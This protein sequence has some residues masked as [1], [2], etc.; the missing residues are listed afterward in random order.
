MTFAAFTYL[1]EILCFSALLSTT[2]LIELLQNIML[3][4]VTCAQHLGR[5][6]CVTPTIP[7]EGFHF[8]YVTFIGFCTF[9]NKRLNTG[10]HVRTSGQTTVLILHLH[11]HSMMRIFSRVSALS[12]QMNKSDL[13]RTT[14][15]VTIT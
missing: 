5:E 7:F 4:H 15:I 8:M 1:A 11:L 12:T 3:L 14:D 2:K 6:L 9:H 10:I 13:R